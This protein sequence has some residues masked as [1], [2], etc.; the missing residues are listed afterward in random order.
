MA[1]EQPGDSPTYQ[2]KSCIP[3]R[4]V[5][6]RLRRVLPSSEAGNTVNRK[7]AAAELPRAAV[8]AIARAGERIVG[9]GAIKRARPAYAGRIAKRSEFA[10]DPDMPELGYVA[11]DGNHGNRG[12]SRRIVVALLS[13]H[14]GTLF[15]TTD[16]DY[17]KKTL[18]GAGFVQNGQE[19]KGQ[20]GR[21]SLW[22]RTIAPQ[23]SS[24]SPGQ[25]CGSDRILWS[26]I[27]GK[28]KLCLQEGMDL[29][30]S[31]FLSA[32]YT[33]HFATTERRIPIHG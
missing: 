10:F 13:E 3:A 29:Q 9:V 17:M 28:C 18:A 4:S 24:E 20:R 21:L 8:L 22:I 5:R 16:S 32:G 27:K 2:V 11:V 12:L 6:W 33:E 15:A 19:W 7:S 25:G 26:M 23:G 31:H 30:D 14:D 1:T